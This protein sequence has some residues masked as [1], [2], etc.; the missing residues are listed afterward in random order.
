MPMAKTRRGQIAAALV[1]AGAWLGA[2]LIG[3]YNAF[4]RF[5]TLSYHLSMSVAL[6]SVAGSLL[7]AA[8]PRA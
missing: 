1:V 8:P 2:S 4:F 7:M 6:M 3:V 5:P